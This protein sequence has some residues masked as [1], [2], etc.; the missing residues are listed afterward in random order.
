[1]TAFVQTLH[2]QPST[3]THKFGLTG[4]N[5]TTPT[6]SLKYQRCLSQLHPEK[7]NLRKTIKKVVGHQIQSLLFSQIN[8]LTFSKPKSV[9]LVS[10]SSYIQH[11]EKA[12]FSF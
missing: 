8:K 11:T 4:M 2:V 9:S 3:S 6:G 10:A 5:R 12:K 1:M 7:D